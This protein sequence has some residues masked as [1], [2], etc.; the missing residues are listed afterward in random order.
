MQ[1]TELAARAFGLPSATHT[2]GWIQD[3]PKVQEDYVRLRRAINDGD[4]IAAVDAMQ[5]YVFLG[6]VDAYIRL[7]KLH[8]GELAKY[9]AET[10]E[11]FEIP[12]IGDREELLR[13]K[14]SSSK[15]WAIIQYDTVLSTG[16]RQ[17]LEM[18]FMRVETFEE[19]KVFV[20]R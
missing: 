19:I 9:L 15:M 18:F 12:F 5:A 13:M 3:K 1:P 10:D 20:S 8:N 7:R 2:L 17:A 11:Y 6:R 4:T 16:I 14:D